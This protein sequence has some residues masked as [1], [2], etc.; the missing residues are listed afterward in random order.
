[1]NNYHLTIFLSLKSYLVSDVIA[2][3]LIYVKILQDIYNKPFNEMEKEIITMCVKKSWIS[4]S[5]NEFETSDYNGE[6]CFEIKDGTKINCDNSVW[7]TFERQKISSFIYS[8]SR[9]RKIYGIHLHF[10][11]PVPKE[12]E[13]IK[14]KIQSLIQL[15]SQ[16]KHID[17]DFK[18]SKRKNF[19]Y[20]YQNVYVNRHDESITYTINEVDE[21]SPLG[22]GYGWNSYS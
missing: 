2:H 10:G 5:I 1:M 11:G 6:K 8:D 18:A 7:F 15:K 22:W 16:R 9:I 12:V 13:R 17:F 3:I 19:I 14:N 4:N 21:D 20:V